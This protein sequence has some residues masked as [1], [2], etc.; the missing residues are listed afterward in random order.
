VNNRFTA[1]LNQF[2]PDDRQFQYPGDAF[3]VHSALNV[4]TTLNA[5]DN[6]HIPA[7][8]GYSEVMENLDRLTHAL[9]SGRN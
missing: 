1:N 9:S 8:Q 3:T 5:I 6:K 7:W 4:Y 2:L